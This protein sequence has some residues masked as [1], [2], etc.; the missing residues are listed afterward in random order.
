MN[1]TYEIVSETS[2]TESI[3][4]IHDL[5][6]KQTPF[7]FGLNFNAYGYGKFIIDDMS[8]SAF[9]NNLMHI[10][11]RL[12]RKQVYCMLYDMIKC[13]AVSASRVM[14]IIENNL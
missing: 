2:A 8:L 7:A 10:K 5:K 6:G 4:E 13:G 11:D 3:T 9:E 1:V 14:R 12:N